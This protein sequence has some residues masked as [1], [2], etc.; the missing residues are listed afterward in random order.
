MASCRPRSLGT[1]SSEG[2]QNDGGVIELLPRIGD[3]TTK[4]DEQ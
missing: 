4:M 1:G 3:K 2:L